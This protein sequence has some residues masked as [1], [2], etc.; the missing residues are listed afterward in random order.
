ME[1]KIPSTDQGKRIEIA[2]LKQRIIVLQMKMAREVWTATLQM[3]RDRGADDLAELAT[4]IDREYSQRF[5]RHRETLMC[6]IAKIE[7][8]DEVKT[9]KK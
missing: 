5:L 1:D 2:K 7:L 4:Q 6:K 9:T 3:L 8:G